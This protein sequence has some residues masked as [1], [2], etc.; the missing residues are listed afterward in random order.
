MKELFV[1]C[2]YGLSGDML[3]SALVDLGADVD[4][5]VS[6]LKKLPI[7]DFDLHFHTKNVLGITASHLHLH[8]DGVVIDDAVEEHH[9]HDH[10]HEH[11]HSHDHEHHHHH[12]HTHDH[13]HQHHHDEEGHEHSHHH[14]HHSAKKIFEM[15]ET[16]E[17]PAGVK[18]RSLALFKEVAR[19]EGKIHGMSPDEVHFH[20]VGAIDSVI[21]MIGVCLALENLGIEKLTF[22]P[23]PTGY[24]KVRIAH[25]LYPVP[26]PA[27][28]EILVGVPLSSFTYQSELTTP[29]GAAFAKVLASDYQQAPSGEMEKIGYGAGTKE[30]PHPNVCRVILLKK[31]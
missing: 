24:G 25:G 22:T 8:V 28:A 17:L 26:A 16:S 12:E 27:T 30:F 2:Q 18:Q 29:T 31:N 11:E 19:A 23:I 15:I 7:Q 21:D 6:E 13:E 10:D 20:E 3:L 1:D 4:Y 5:I 9:H 14:E